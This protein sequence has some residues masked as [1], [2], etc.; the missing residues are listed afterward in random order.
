MPAP[1]DPPSRPLLPA[2]LVL[3]SRSPRR[4]QLLSE[5]GLPHEAVEPGIDDGL[6]EPGP[7]PPHQWVTA[8]AYLKAAAAARTLAPDRPALVL[9]AD[10]VVVKGAALIG[11][12]A[13]AADA[14]RIIRLLQDGHH[15]VIS[16][17]ALLRTDRP[18]WRRMFVDRAR[19][20]V[21]HIG[22]DA[23][24]AYIAGGN[25]RGKAGA[26]NLAERIEA[27]WPIQY[28]GDPTTIM[29]LPMRMLVDRLPRLAGA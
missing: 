19:V 5:F 25:W 4:R 16:G 23:I 28:Q 1:S 21:G 22:D 13:D 9:G 3:A 2:P 6:L 29:G 27:G 11:Q 8:L 10:T 7:V 12:P 18:G 14:E 17:V 15:E 26:Y 20:R 24:R